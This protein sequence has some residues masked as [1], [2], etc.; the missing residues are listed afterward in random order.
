MNDQLSNALSYAHQNHDKTLDILKEFIRKPSISTDPNVE[1]EVKSTSKWVA[2]QLR[3]IGFENV[4]IYETPRHPI[5]YGELL[6]AGES[7]PT[8]LFYGHYDVQP[9]EPLDLWESPPFE[10]TVRGENLYGRGASDMKGQVMVGMAAIEALINAGDLPVNVKFLVE[11]EEEIGSPNLANFIQTHQELLKSDFAVN[12]DGGM[13]GPETPTITYGLRGLAYFEIRLSGPV[14]DLHSGMFGGVVHNPAQI[15]CE[16]IAGMHDDQGK[17]TLPGY[18]DSVCELTEDERTELSRLPMTEDFYLELTGAPDLHGEIGFSP[19]ERIGARPT[20]EVNGLLSGFTGE[21]SKTV[22]PA[23]AMAKISMRL[24]PNQ[25]PKLV[26]R[27]LI[28]YMNEKAPS[29]VNWEIINLAGNKAS[30]MDRNIPEVRALSDAMEAT[31]GKKPLFR[32]EGG[33]VPVVSYMSEILNI[34]SVLTGFGLPDDNLHG[35][36]EKLHLS[37]FYRGI[38]TIIRYLDNLGSISSSSDR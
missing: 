6:L 11:G 22:L 15:L 21:G 5:V 12:L 30:I 9:P 13:L 18:Y 27:Q 16:L 3:R 25:D 28:E 17:V 4:S 14:Q 10:P 2:D 33:S 20:L 31:W 8:V 34:N 23:E 7:K 35:P 29:T 32:R 24:V 36:N 1:K 38:E 26:E 37:T 19:V